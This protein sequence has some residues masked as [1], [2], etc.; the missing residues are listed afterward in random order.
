[1][2]LCLSTCSLKI[3]SKLTDIDLLYG[4]INNK[5][6]IFIVSYSEK[7]RNLLKDVYDGAGRSIVKLSC[8]FIKIPVLYN[9]QI[10]KQLPTYVPVPCPEVPIIGDQPFWNIAYIWPISSLPQHRLDWSPP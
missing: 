2:S 8:P 9:F 1:M 5:T 7:F 10:S 4:K 3:L 6:S